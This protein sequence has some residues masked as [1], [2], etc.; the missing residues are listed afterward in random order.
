MEI[1][2]KYDDRKLRVVISPILASKLCNLGHPIVKIKPKRG[3]VIDNY[4]CNT[5]FLF[6]DT[7]D[8]KKDFDRLIKEVEE[9]K[10]DGR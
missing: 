10:N 8:F 6:E 1:E 7:E 4:Q 2:N 5:V 9:Q 3:L